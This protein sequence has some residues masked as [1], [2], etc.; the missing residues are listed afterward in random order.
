MIIP[1]GHDK[2]VALLPLEFLIADLRR[3]FAAKYMMDHRTRM[4]MRVRLIAGSQKLQGALDRRH[5]RPAGKRLAIFQQI[6]V[7][8]ISCGWRLS[9]SAQSLFRLAPFVMKK[10]G[11]RQ[12]M[13]NRTAK[14]IH[15]RFAAFLDR[16]TAFGIALLH[17]LVQRRDEWKI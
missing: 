10:V 9:Q 5:R 12:P 3:S 15:H 13:A 6:A 16:L 14:L 8:A 17:D 1:Q 2:R 11:K 7:E 4:A